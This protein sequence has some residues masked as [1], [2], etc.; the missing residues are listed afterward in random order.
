MTAVNNITIKKSTLALEPDWLVV[1]MEILIREVST[2]NA[3][4]TNVATAKITVFLLTALEMATLILFRT[5][6][7]PHFGITKDTQNTLLQSHFIGCYYYW[8]WCFCILN[9]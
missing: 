6:Y 7:F 8:Y 5:I 4:N 2:V 1:R 3:T 9:T